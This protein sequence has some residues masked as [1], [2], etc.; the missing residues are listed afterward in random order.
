[1]T[2]KISSNLALSETGFMFSPA[3]GDTFTLNETGVFI[4]NLIKNG[5]NPEA[6]IHALIDEYDIDEKTVEGDL[7]D[8]INQLKQHK[9]V[10][11]K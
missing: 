8:F 7:E 9:L 6:I 4:I 1:M 5:K 10:E 3:T 2:L 11:I